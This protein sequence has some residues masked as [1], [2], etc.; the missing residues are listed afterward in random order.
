MRSLDVLGIQAARRALD[1]VR[2]TL[3]DAVARDRLARID[4]V[5]SRVVVSID[6]ATAEPAA[7]E[8]SISGEVERIRQ[9]EARVA[10]F[11]PGKGKSETP[12]EPL[13]ALMQRYLTAKFPGDTGLAVTSARYLPGGRS[14]HTYIVEITG[15]TLLPPKIVLRADSTR[16]T[17]Y[18]DVARE[19]PLIEAV[20][21][22]GCPAPEPLW[23]EPDTSV[24][25]GAFIA[26]AHVPGAVAGDL[27]GAAA[28]NDDAA[29]ALAAALAMLHALPVPAIADADGLSA[30]AATRLLFETY[31][32]RWHE[33][34]L[35][36]SVS[37]QGAFEFLFAKADVLNGPAGIVHGDAHFANMLMHE[38]RLA[39]LLDWEFW[40]AGHPAEDLAYCRP[41]VEQ[42]MK[43]AE[44]LALYAAAGGTPPAAAALDLFAVWRPLRNAVLAANVAYHFQTREDLDLETAAIALSTLPKMEA[45]VALALQR[46]LS[47]GG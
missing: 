11:D 17:I 6:D 42:T 15:S 19:Y 18:D 12:R 2:D 32:R 5:L 47:G 25:G 46:A 22:A 26:F 33:A 20:F 37:M 10:G 30:M 23:F 7:A 14:K 27:Y 21:K 8:T 28:G 45:Q 36:P 31:Q 41:Y 4:I 39:G 24:I 16:T 44:F 29:R 40:H 9:R 43:W 35:G 3:D 34:R 13:T 1:Q 38:G